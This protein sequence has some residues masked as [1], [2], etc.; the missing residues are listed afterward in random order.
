MFSNFLRYFRG[1]WIYHLSHLL[2]KLGGAKM[3]KTI[4]FPGAKTKVKR[5][6]PIVNEYDFEDVSKAI[7][8]ICVCINNRSILES[9]LSLNWALGEHKHHGKL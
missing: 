5:L 8:C 9:A 7:F 1:K 6:I 3:I 4:D 2:Y